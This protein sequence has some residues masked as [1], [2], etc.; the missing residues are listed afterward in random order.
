MSAQICFD[1]QSPW[2]TARELESL[3]AVNNSLIA[4]AIQF[5]PI[6]EL[7]LKAEKVARCLTNNAIEVIA[8]SPKDL[9]VS[10]KVS[11]NTS[12][13]KVKI[14]LKSNLKKIDAFK[15]LIFE[16]ANVLIIE[17]TA[18]IFQDAKLRLI[19]QRVFVQEVEK[20]EYKSVLEYQEVVKQLKER[21]AKLWE[22]LP[23]GFNNF[24]EYVAHQ[25][26]TGHIQQYEK[27]WSDTFHMQ[28]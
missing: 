4:E 15:H 13:N 7:Y 16:L 3:P 5:P 28:R 23:N 12:E 11:Y 9:P 27:L 21:S 19:G 26:R 20:V 6:N 8:V 22:A 25:E 14:H 2:L 18:K 24:N 1:S 10:A 17:E